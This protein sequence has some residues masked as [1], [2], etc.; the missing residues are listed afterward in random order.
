MEGF[1]KL[2]RII[3]IGLVIAMVFLVVFVRAGQYG[4]L[5]GGEQAGRI[6]EAGTAGLA[7]IIR[8]ATGGEGR[9]RA[10]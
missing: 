10:A 2:F 3:A 9:R 1:L 4:R 7:T 5:S 8:V 6:I